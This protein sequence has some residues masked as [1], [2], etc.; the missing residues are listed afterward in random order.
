MRVPLGLALTAAH[1]QDLPALKV[2]HS[3]KPQGQKCSFQQGRGKVGPMQVPK[4]LSPPLP[5]GDLPF[6]CLSLGWTASFQSRDGVLLN[7]TYAPGL[8]SG[9]CLLSTHLSLHLP[10]CLPL[11]L[12]LSYSPLLSASAPHLTFFLASTSSLSPFLQLCVCPPLCLPHPRL[13]PH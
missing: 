9:S 13:L 11:P 4:G 10:L 3:P 2:G 5:K 7:Y 1:S 6:S 8:T 12:P